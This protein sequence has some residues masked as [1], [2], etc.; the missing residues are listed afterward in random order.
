MA[1]IVE[2]NKIL[3]G[4][5]Q[6][7]RT[8]VAYSCLQISMPFDQKSLDC[9]IVLLLLLSGHCQA[10]QGSCRC[11]LRSSHKYLA[12]GLQSSIRTSA[13][14]LNAHMLVPITRL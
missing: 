4:Q 8:S 12:L 10:I 13:L 2:F 7:E 1:N 3:Q 14:R 5:Q 6:Q 11:G 9:S